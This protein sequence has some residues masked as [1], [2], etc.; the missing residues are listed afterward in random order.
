MVT[1]ALGMGTSLEPEVNKE[2]TT[3]LQRL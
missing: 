3:S 1:V 2:S